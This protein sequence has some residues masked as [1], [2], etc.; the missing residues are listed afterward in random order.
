VERR[1]GGREQR[2][3]RGSKE[4]ASEEER[5]SVPKEAITGHIG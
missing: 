3:N 1:R 2:K 4:G 5:V